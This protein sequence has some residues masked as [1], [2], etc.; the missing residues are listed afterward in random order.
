MKKTMPLSWCEVLCKTHSD[1]TV[2]H[3]YLPNS[4]L[5]AIAKT[6][7]T[8]VLILKRSKDPSDKKLRNNLLVDIANLVSYS[9]VVLYTG[10]MEVRDFSP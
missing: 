2:V 4:Y 1:K 7:Q 6:K 8:S 10:I 9:T 3:V 5:Y